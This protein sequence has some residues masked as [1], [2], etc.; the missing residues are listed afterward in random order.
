MPQIKQYNQ[1]ID[2]SG[3][4]TVP[5][6]NGN[7]FGAGVAQEISHLGE[8][9]TN[10]GMVLQQRANQEDI[11]EL[12]TRMARAQAD[13][14]VDYQKQLQE[15]TLETKDFMDSVG[16]KMDAVQQ[17]VN[18]PSGRQSFTR[19]NAELHAHF[20]EKAFAGQAQIA[21][22]KAKSNHIESL[23]DRSSTVYG[24]PS[25]FELSLKQQYD[26]VDSLVA[27]GGLSAKDAPKLK[28]EDAVKLAMS[29]AEGSIR[30]NP[31]VAE[32]AIMK[33]GI[34]DEYLTGQ[35]KDAL[36]GTIRQ[37]RNGRLAEDERLRRQQEKIL[38]EQ[39]TQTQNQFLDKLQAGELSW[40]DVKSSNL[41]PFGSGSKE[42]FIQLMKTKNADR[43]A[44]SDPY[45]FRDVFSR[46]HLPAGDPKRITDENELNQYFI[47]G[48]ISLPDLKSLRGEITDKGTIEGDVNSTLKK[49]FTDMAFNSI[50][51][52]DPTTKIADPEGAKNYQ[53]WL[54]GMLPR[55]QKA[56][57]AGKN[58]AD[59]FNP[60]N[61]EY[62]GKDIPQFQRSLDQIIKSQIEGRKS[63]N[64]PPNTTEMEFPDGSRQFVPNANVDK[65]KE[66]YK[67]KVRVQ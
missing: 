39:Q 35:Q 55:Y 28:R 12:N 42:T 5:Q 59:L 4:T 63:N 52:P 16:E 18:T 14:T 19:A 10:T 6:A 30:L 46:V 67:A 27:T 47:K 21:G 54:S 25:Q 53:R 50:A 32:Q 15:G 36:L 1:Q 7:T 9:L 37:E 3:P 40:N 13:I 17:G 60:D 31:D 65:A 38:K 57:A 58:P 2:A 23:T 33:D 43:A 62:L 66:K 24:D 64:A 61:P 41:D 20:L 8:N 51:K 26:T 34:Y 49:N 11:S 48:Q 45:V 56:I 29:A 44:H 22:E